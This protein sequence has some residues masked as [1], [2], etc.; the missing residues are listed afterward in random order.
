[1]SEGTITAVGGEFRPKVDLCGPL[2]KVELNL[3]PDV[4]NSQLPQSPLSRN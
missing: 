4:D 3:L 2:P 1:M